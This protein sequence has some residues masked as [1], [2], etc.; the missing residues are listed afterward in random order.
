MSVIDEQWAERV[1]QKLL[2]E[3]PGAEKLRIDDSSGN[4]IIKLNSGDASRSVFKVLSPSREKFLAHEKKLHFALQ[5]ACGQYYTELFVPVQVTTIGGEEGFL[6]PQFEYTLRDLLFSDDIEISTLSERMISGLVQAMERLNLLRKCT[7]STFDERFVEEL[8][9]T[10]KYLRE[11]LDNE[12]PE[13]LRHLTQIANMVEKFIPRESTWCHRDFHLDSLAYLAGQYRLFDPLPTLEQKPEY[14]DRIEHLEPP[15]KGHVFLDYA[16]L[17]ISLERE[18]AKLEKKGYPERRD[19]LLQMKQVFE[20][21]AELQVGRSALHLGNLIYY[22]RYALCRCDHCLQWGIWP[23]MLSGL[24]CT[25]NQL[26]C[27]DLATRLSDDGTFKAVYGGNT[28][29]LIFELPHK[30]QRAILKMEFVSGSSAASSEVGK[31]LRREVIR[32]LRGYEAMPGAI[33]PAIFT[34]G[35]YEQLNFLLMEHAGTEFY[36]RLIEPLDEKLYHQLETALWK[37]YTDSAEEKPDQAQAF[38]HSILQKLEENL[39]RYIQPKHKIEVA[40]GQNIIELLRRVPNSALPNWCFWAT[41]DFTV[42]NLFYKDNRFIF[43]DPKEA[44]P[45]IFEVDL[46]MFPTLIAIYARSP[47]RNTPPI[48]ETNVPFYQDKIFSLAQAIRSQYESLDSTPFLKL[49]AAWQC[50]LSSRFREGEEAIQLYHKAVK[51]LIEVQHSLY[52]TQIE[53]G[54]S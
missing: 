32:N 1:F 3:Y 24:D 47:R 45:G 26:L 4:V 12:K 54:K 49:G 6:S 43:I 35:Q 52:N 33:R 5:E 34:M 41:T 19:L 25:I 51:L 29:C 18:A 38:Y 15:I 30:G 13:Q 9:I 37:A 17:A 20:Q 44:L 2:T 53:R 39:L 36:G 14:V 8:R 48:H 11:Q 42:N 28:D 23:V 22:S 50:I 46:G 27:D 10:I 21:K 16:E 7:L 31:D 40:E